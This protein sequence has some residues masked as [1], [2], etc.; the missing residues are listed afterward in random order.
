MVDA[1]ISIVD[2]SKSVL[3]LS[4]YAANCGCERLMTNDQLCQDKQ[5]KVWERMG[6]NPGGLKPNGNPVG[7]CSESG[8]D[9]I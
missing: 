3:G 2:V 7:T 1:L 8:S 5:P 6:T 4:A 9:R